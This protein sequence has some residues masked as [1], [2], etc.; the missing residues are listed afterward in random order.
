MSTRIAFA[1]GVYAVKFS[2]FGTNVEA[3]A[4]KKFMQQANNQDGAEFNEII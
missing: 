4:D 1:R 2:K 3:L